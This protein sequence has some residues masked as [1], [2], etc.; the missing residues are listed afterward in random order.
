M[1]SY[2]WDCELNKA[3]SAACKCLHGWPNLWQIYVITAFLT[4]THATR[5]TQDEQNRTNATDGSR[6]LSSPRML[7]SHRARSSFMGSR[8]ASC[9]L[10]SHWWYCCM[11]VRPGTLGCL[12]LRELH[13][14]PYW[15]PVEAES[16]H[17]HNAINNGSDTDPDAIKPSSIIMP[18]VILM[19]LCLQSWVLLDY[20]CGDDN[21]NFTSLCLLF[22]ETCPQ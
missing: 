13:M 9:R 1:V 11:S 8:L 4:Q 14:V 12:G 19:I 10:A 21:I 2:F 7:V 6:R 17:T 22:S 3:A 18:S 20:V 5:Y 15:R 16:R